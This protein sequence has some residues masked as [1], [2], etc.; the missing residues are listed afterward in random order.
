[1]SKQNDFY[2]NEATLKDYLEFR[3]SPQSPNET[4]EK[5]AFLELLGDVQNKHILDLGV[6]MPDLPMIF[7]KKVVRLIRVLNPRVSCLDTP[8]KICKIP[9]VP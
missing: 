7:F 8:K 6:A 2:Q 1:M 5:P 4:I 3:H 9:R